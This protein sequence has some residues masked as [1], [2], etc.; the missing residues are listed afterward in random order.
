MVIH[1]IKVLQSLASS[2]AEG[3]RGVSGT[4]FPIQP[5]KP[6]KLYEFEGSPFCRR[7]REAITLLN[8]DV[9]IYPCPKGGQKY[10]QIVKEKGGKLQFPFLIDENTGDQL[11]ESQDIIHHLFKY[12]GKTGKTPAT[13]SHYPKIPMPEFAGTLL[14]MARGVWVN[15]KIIHR[16]APEQLLELWSFE[17]SP[18]SRIVRATLTELEIPYILHNVPKERWQDMGP[19]V[20]RLKPGKYEPLA[21]GK[22]EK[23]LPEMQGKMQVPYLVDPNTGVKM[24]ESAQ[25]VKYLKKQY[26]KA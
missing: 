6:L 5:A 4:P 13:Y 25:I 3:G 7:V 19:A 8:L 24:F 20:L 17:A 14:N 21:G 18:Y 1:Q 11:F 2:L 16:A 12:Y 9:E 23:M 22:R 15:K 26:G 10:R